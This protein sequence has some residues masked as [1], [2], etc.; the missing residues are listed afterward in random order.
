MLPTEIHWKIHFSTWFSESEMSRQTSIA[1][2]I[3]Y[4]SKQIHYRTTAPGQ[5]TTNNNRAHLAHHKEMEHH[6]STKQDYTCQD[7]GTTVQ[8]QLGARTSE[9]GNILQV[10]THTRAN[11]NTLHPTCNK[12]IQHNQTCNRNDLLFWTLHHKENC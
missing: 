2:S 11:H 5:P 9:A 8:R 3:W 12:A 1:E 7:S 6:S 4:T 10:D